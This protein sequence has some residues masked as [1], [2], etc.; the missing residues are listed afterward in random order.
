V[1]AVSGPAQG[2]RTAIGKSGQDASR[3]PENQKTR[4]PEN[5][6][7]SFPETPD[8]PDP[9]YQNIWKL[10]IPQTVESMLVDIET[11]IKRDGTILDSLRETIARLLADRGSQADATKME[12]ALKRLEKIF[13][14]RA[15]KRVEDVAQST[16][17]PIA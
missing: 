2:Q 16:N 14:R 6:K 13:A 10:Y 12:K 17:V 5:Q 1:T 8:F 7:S 4:K 3:K 11:E 9:T 15:R